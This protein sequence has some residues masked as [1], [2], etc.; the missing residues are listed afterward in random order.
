MYDIII[1]GAGINGLVA[2]L[3]FAEAGFS[4]C[5]IDV[6]GNPV[7]SLLQDN[8]SLRC[9]AINYASKKILEKLAIDLKNLT[10]TPYHSMEIWEELGYGKITFKAE[11][12]PVPYLGKIIEND[13]LQK[14]LIK[15]LS[16]YSEVTQLWNTAP[17]QFQNHEH[18]VSLHLE[19]NH[20]VNGL[21]IVGADG[22]NSWLAKTL[23]IPLKKYLY[24]QNAL[25]TTVIHEQSHLNTAYQR[26]NSE[27]P[28][29][30]LPLNKPHQSSIVWTH[31]SYQSKDILSYSEN[32][33]G[34][35]LGLNI[36]YK[37]G[38][39]Q[40]IQESRIFPLFSQSL[41]HYI[42][43][44]V[45][46]IGDSAHVIHPLAGQGLNLGIMDAAILVQ[47]MQGAFLKGKKINNYM[48]LRSYER[49]RKTSGE[50][51]LFMVDKLNTLFNFKNEGMVI[52]RSFMMNRVQS[53]L[54]FKKML[55]DYALGFKEDLALMSKEFD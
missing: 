43:P 4:V 55:M 2:S 8:K 22:A 6:Q 23:N 36:D 52:A 42:I 14:A 16:A 25:V 26:F 49:R 32:R 17:M 37:L 51:M 3:L 10:A 12:Y 13:L 15:K 7:D 11:D 19:N 20:N 28:L 53:T 18:Y 9:S 54:F 44:N 27:G 33:L 34:E 38:K 48:A 30:F 47:T 1:L 5:I 31:P 39:V 40:V 35:K 41:N 29:A 21:L 50:R 46:F 24:N 45:A